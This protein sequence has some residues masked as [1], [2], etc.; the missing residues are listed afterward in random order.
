LLFEKADDCTKSTIELFKLR[1]IDS[2]ADFSSFLVA[3]LL[4]FSVISLFVIIF[5]IGVALW[6]GNL[7]GKYYYG[8][9]ISSL[10]WFDFSF[11]SFQL[12]P[13]DKSANQ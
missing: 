13:M 10:L 6:I 8:F 5:Y 7:L 1:A 12:V 4:L 3:K 11:S 2:S 9:F